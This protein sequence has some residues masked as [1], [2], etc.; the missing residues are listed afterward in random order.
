MKTI[1]SKA[2]DKSPSSSSLRSAANP[3]QPATAIR[4]NVDNAS[5]R[6]THFV[7]RNVEGETKT[8]A[9]H[10]PVPVPAMV[11]EELKRNEPEIPG[12][13]Y[14]DGSGTFAPRQRQDH[15]RPSHP[16]SLDAK[17]GGKREGG[18]DADSF[19]ETSAPFSTLIEG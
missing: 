2:I 4:L 18:R 15:G 13:R 14:Q 12:H 16:D 10:E 3:S 17:E 5:A 1:I 9:S 19:S 11:L 6:V 7:Y 8:V